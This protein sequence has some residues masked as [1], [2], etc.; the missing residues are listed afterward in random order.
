LIDLHTGWTE[1][2]GVSQE[3]EGLDILSFASVSESI[4]DRVTPGFTTL[5]N[6]ARYYALYCWILH[7]YFNGGYET[8]EFEPFFR[9]REHAYALACVSHVHEPGTPGGDAIVGARSSGGR[10]RAG[11]EP[12]NL[13]KSHIKARFGGYGNYRNAMQR[14]GLLK[15]AEG[16]P[17][18][19]TE[20]STGAPSG[21]KLAEAFQS[22]IE[23]TTYFRR[24]RDEYHVPR[25]VIEEYGRAACLCEMSGTPDGEVLCRA[26]LQPDPPESDVA[27]YISP[28]P[29]PSL[30][31]STS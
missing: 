8:E 7:D 30:L 12:L 15:L 13:A 31:S 23:D 16:S 17:D 10:W 18:S 27:A 28:A 2:H 26:F 11:D 25:A 5:T 21:R 1:A 19:L 4:Y 29:E 24:Y 9:R 22:V 6:R 3:D 20:S 14:A